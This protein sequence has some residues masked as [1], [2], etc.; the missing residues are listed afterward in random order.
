[1][2]IVDKD[3]IIPAKQTERVFLTWTIHHSC[4]Y[5]CSYCFVTT[6]YRDVFM[7]NTYPGLEK[8]IE[9][10]ERVYKLYGSCIIKLAGGEPFTYPNFMELLEHLTRHHFLDFSSNLYWDVEEF[11]RRIPGNSARI[12]PSYHPEFCPSKEEFAEKCLALKKHGFMGSVHMVGYPTLIDKVIEAKAYFESRGLN[13]VILPFRGAYKDKQYPDAY[14]DDEKL[15][16]KIAIGAA[17][18]PNA[19][20]KKAE[21]MSEEKKHIQD[22]NKRYFDWY[23]GK[24]NNLKES[25][26]RWCLHGA[27]YGKIQP[28]GD[29]LRCCTPTT[30]EKHKELIIGNILDPNFKLLEGAKQCDISPCFC[31]KPMLLEQDE[32]WKP[33][34]R[35]ETYAKPESF[36]KPKAE[37]TQGAA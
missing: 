29:V 16:L 9:V 5:R 37:E 4:N 21:P 35:F 36:T 32:T 12:E 25:E 31:W 15:K 27:Y 2:P 10:W 11:V 14:S 7:N 6:G 19:P 20:E 8:W 30:P 17:P 28:N 26:V 13:G 33:L 1:M 18:A 23:V 24:E 34:W 22:V 3:R